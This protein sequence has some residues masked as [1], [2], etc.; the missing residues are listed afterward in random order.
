M[1]LRANTSM[2]WE[3]SWQ[4]DSSEESSYLAIMM[5]KNLAWSQKIWLHVP[6]A[7]WQRSSAKSAPARC[8]QEKAVMV[9]PGYSPIPENAAQKEVQRARRRNHH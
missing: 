3:A 4:T 6:C 2:H 7:Y 8:W 1:F 9:T 5:I